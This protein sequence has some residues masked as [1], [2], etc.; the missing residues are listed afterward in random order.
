M[1][2]LYFLHFL[3]ADMN[4]KILA[5]SAVFALLIAPSVYAEQDGMGSVEMSDKLVNVS[6]IG[7][8]R[9]IPCNGRKL[10]VSGSGH[11]I[12]ATGEC[13]SVE[14]TGSDISVDV[15]IAPKGTLVVAGS[16]NQVRWKAVG[17]IKRDV[18][19]VG[20]TIARVK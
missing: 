4:T 19:G 10:E 1:L 5:I 17:E 13:A 9:T 7:H 20:H 11:V 16:G 15:A 3:D 8:Q 12:T 2:N 6:G 18:S 14:V